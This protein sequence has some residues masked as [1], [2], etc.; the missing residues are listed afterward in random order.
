MPRV[1]ESQECRLRAV[2]RKGKEKNR[3]WVMNM[4]AGVCNGGKAY[5]GTVAPTQSNKRTSRLHNEVDRGEKG[6]EE[7]RE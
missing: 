4:A 1:V 3:R 6:E 7:G 2:V 5:A